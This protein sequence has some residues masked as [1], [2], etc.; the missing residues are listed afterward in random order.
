MNIDRSAGCPIDRLTLR[1]SRI[2]T[3]LMIACLSAVLVYASD[4]P[5]VNA[6]KSGDREAVRILVEQ[7]V[8]VNLA[9]P[10]GTT[11]LHWAV[12]RD[13]SEMVALLLRAGAVVKTV[14]RF[15]VA[16]LSLACINGNADIVET[17]LKA[18]A[19]PNTSLPEGETALMTAART[20][21]LDAVKALLSY[22]ADP[23]AKETWRGGQ[24][25]LMWA[26]A[27]GHSSVVKT[28]IEHGADFNVRSAGHFTALLFAVREGKSDTVRVLLDSGADVNETLLATVRQRGV[29]APKPAPGPSALVLA[30]ANA[31]YE[32][33]SL[34]LERGA[35]PNAAE[36]GWTALHTITW[37]RKA[38]VGDNPPAPQGLGNMDSLQLVKR[39]AAHGADLNARITKEPNVLTD[40]TMIG[41]TPFLMAAR[42]ADVELM[43]LLADLGADP[44]L[45][46]SEDTTPLMAAAGVGTLNAKEDPG[47]ESE[48]LEAV[49]LAVALGGDVNGVD[50]NGDTA[51][52]GAA[53]KQVPSVVPFLVETGIQTAIWTQKNKNGWTPLRI[54]DGIHRVN[55]FR[56]SAPVAAELRKAMAA[57]GV[58]TEVEPEKVINGSNR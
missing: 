37:V 24:T 36:A 38:G 29:S 50:K 25:A 14:N 47:S 11:A 17:L 4:V 43:R 41:A 30:V 27:D 40:L 23:D 28:L 10:D 26:A 18:G 5:L 51:L 53:S 52:H 6:V 46:N 34:L 57:V 31:H 22:G 9:E 20:G 21:K 16:P 49:K 55:A 32:L 44:L 8:D 13:D 42:T 3:T 7:R 58:S 1:L 56:S 48:V 35:N 15:G 12:Q 19:D 39:L 2:A 33:A 45:P 54:A